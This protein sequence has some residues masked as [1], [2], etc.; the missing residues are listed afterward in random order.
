MPSDTPLHHLP[1][2]PPELQRLRAENRRL[3]QVY[4]RAVETFP[5]NVQM[6]AALKEWW[7]KVYYD[8]TNEQGG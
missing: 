8:F 2:D 6:P 1:S 3:R 7:S 5:Q 4:A